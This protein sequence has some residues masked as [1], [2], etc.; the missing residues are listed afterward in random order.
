MISSGWWYQMNWVCPK[1]IRAG[2]LSWKM[3]I[4]HHINVKL[5]ALDQKTGIVLF[6]PNIGL[7]ERNEKKNR[8][9]RKTSRDRVWRL[10]FTTIHDPNSF[11]V[12]IVQTQ[13]VINNRK[14]KL[15]TV[16]QIPD[17]KFNC[18]AERQT[19]YQIASIS[20]SFF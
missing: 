13:C 1:E 20:R 15:S 9:E 17:M 19:I 4:D 11:S 5:V 12:F 10:L 18:C 2:I 6:I 8:F 3:W 14:I 16:H 7:I